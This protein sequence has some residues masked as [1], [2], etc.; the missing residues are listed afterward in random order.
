MGD[1][2]AGMGQT[3]PHS[4]QLPLSESSLTQVD[5]HKVKPVL[6]RTLQPVAAHRGEPLSAVGHAVPQALQFSGSLWTLTHEPPQ[7]SSAP[8]QVRPHMP[9][10][11]A[12]PGAQAC[13]QAPQLPGSLLVSTHS[14][15]HLAKPLLQVEPQM[16]SMHTAMP[17]DGALQTVSHP[18]QCEISVL[19]SAQPPSQAT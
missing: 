13:P 10:E 6:Q 14:S 3:F 8:A 18:P 7:F 5:P 12:S 4:P 9:A 11:Q 16:P 19:V 2:L 1:P 15:P 17:S